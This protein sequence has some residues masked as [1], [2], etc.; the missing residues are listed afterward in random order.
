MI[1]SAKLHRCP[2]NHLSHPLQG[3]TDGHDALNIHAECFTS[4]VAWQILNGHASLRS[5]SAH[6][7]LPSGCM[8]GIELELDAQSTGLLN[9]CREDDCA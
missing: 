3:M 2:F 9:Y 4:S 8:V 1:E 7:T 6:K 5:Y